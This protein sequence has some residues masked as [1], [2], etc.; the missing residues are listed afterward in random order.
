MFQARQS[1][2]SS[3]PFNTL[4][5][6]YHSIVRDIRKGHRNAVVGMLMNMVQ[7]IIMVLAF[8]AMFWIL[9]G[10]RT[11]AIRG[12]FII[13]LMTGIFL[14]M[15]HT[16]AVGAIVKSE[17]PT[18]SMMQHAPLNAV[19]TISAAALSSLYTQILSISAVLLLYH[20][21]IAPVTIDQPIG[22]IGMFLAA[23]FSGVGVG[24]IFLAIKPWFP[25]LTTIG[26][27][28]YSR[29]NMIASGKMFV[30]NTLPPSMLAIFD[31]NPLFHAIDQCRGFV[32]L[33]YTPHFSSATYPVWI[34]IGL[35]VIGMMA[36]FYTRKTASLSWNAGR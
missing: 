15:A 33:N 5:L 21:I 13:Y 4:E 32:F 12:D 9:P 26:S 1:R 22:T 36:Q 14:F 2:S 23:W 34:G 11:S 3:L 29:V 24:C 7:T 27:S 30:A 10:A 17:G 16:K 18:S 19:V 31:W 6:I 35:L 20:L 8:Y 28:I 25:E